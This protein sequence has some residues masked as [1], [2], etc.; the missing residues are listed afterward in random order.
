MKT[1]LAT[2]IRNHET[3]TSESITVSPSGSSIPLIWVYLRA[4]EVEVREFERH[5][6]RLLILFGDDDEGVWERG[7]FR[8]GVNIPG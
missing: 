2:D 4:S 6:W 5:R 7:R 8:T 1:F 3:G